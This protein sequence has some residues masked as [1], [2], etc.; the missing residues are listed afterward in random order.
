MNILLATHH[1]GEANSLWHRHHMVT[2]IWVNIG[3]GNG[4]L[5]DWVNI[6]SG[7]QWLRLLP[8]CIKPLTDPMLTN[9]QWGSEAFS[10]GLR[11]TSQDM[12]KISMSLKIANLELQ[13]HLQGANEL[14]LEVWRY[15]VRC[16][17]CL[18]VNYGIS[19]IIVLEIPY[20][21]KPVL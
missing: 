1:K 8:D 15:L 10:W 9:H 19:C 18:V 4:L 14:N 13:L 12:L 20:H 7:Q 3:S 5:P 17:R 2:Q 11:A 16:H 6:D 21:F